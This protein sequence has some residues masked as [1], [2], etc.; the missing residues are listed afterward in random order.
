MSVSTSSSTGIRRGLSKVV[1]RWRV[2][3]IVVASVIGVACSVVFLLWNVGYRGAERAAR[4]AAARAAGSARRARGSFAGVLGGLIIRKPGAALYTELVAAVVSALV[5]QPVGAASRS[6]RGS[7]RASAPRSS[8]CSSPTP[9]GVCRSRSSPAR[10]RRSRAAS[11]TGSSGT[12]APTRRSRSST[13]SARRSRAPSS[14]VPA[15]GSLAR[16]LAATGALDRFASGREAPGVSSGRRRV[17]A[18]DGAP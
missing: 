10:A 18:R 14:P 2:V 13:S 7:S 5:G 6:W 8:S 12:R 11:T 15:R 9:S 4:A 1:W 17:S 3:D 16:G